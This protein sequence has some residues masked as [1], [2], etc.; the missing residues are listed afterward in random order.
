MKRGYRCG[1]GE[2]SIK[3]GDQTRKVYAANKKA[4]A[5]ECE[6][7]AKELKESERVLH[8]GSGRKIASAD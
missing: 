2:W 5:A 7:M 3:R 8:A 6:V 1:C 4:H